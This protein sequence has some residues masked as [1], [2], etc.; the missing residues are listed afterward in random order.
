MNAP[1]MQSNR[2]TPE[3][4]QAILIPDQGTTPISRRTERR[5]HAD[6]TVESGFD[7][8]DP[9]RAAR[10]MSRARGKK[11]E[12]TGA[13]GAERRVE[14]AEPIM[15][16]KDRRTTARTGENKAPARTFCKISKVSIEQI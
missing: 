15:V 13:R 16:R 12:R 1:S 11:C 7:R 4:P 6:C 5:I 10:V 3:T 8:D 2:G 14:Q 9:W